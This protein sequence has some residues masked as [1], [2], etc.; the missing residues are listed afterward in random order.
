V[1]SCD[2]ITREISRVNGPLNGHKRRKKRKPVVEQQLSGPNVIK[3]FFFRNLPFTYTV[4][5]PSKPFQSS[6]IFL[7]KARGIPLSGATGRYFTPVG[8]SLK[9]KH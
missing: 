9:F 4:F 3:L 1:L 7:G 5:V 8:S 2:F 6:L